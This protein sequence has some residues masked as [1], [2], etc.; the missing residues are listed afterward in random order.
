ML[1]FLFFINENYFFTKPKT[2][3][4]KALWDCADNFLRQDENIGQLVT[5]DQIYQEWQKPPYGVKR[6]YVTSYMWLISFLD[7]V[8]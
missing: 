1:S 8:I 4:F 7:Q 2:G 5:A 6:G 3:S